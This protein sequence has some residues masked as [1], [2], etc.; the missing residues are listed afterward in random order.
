MPKCNIARPRQPRRSWRMSA[1]CIRR[2]AA[3]GAD[4]LAES[5]VVAQAPR[6]IGCA[7]RLNARAARA[8]KQPMSALAFTIENHKIARAA[9]SARHAELKC[10]T[11]RYRLSRAAPSRATASPCW[12]PA[13]GA[14]FGASAAAG[15]SRKV[16]DKAAKVSR[17]TGKPLATLDVIGAVGFVLRPDPRRRS[18]ASRRRSTSRAG[19]KL[20]GTIQGQIRKSA[21]GRPSISTRPASRSAERKRPTSRSAS[22]CAPTASTSTGPRRTTPTTARS[23]PRSR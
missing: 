4:R 6:R 20:G 8:L 10:P 12:S 22:C 19:W 13:G 3:V 14:K 17:F 16:I 1:T 7:R 9:A 11:H 23:R 5:A 21:E 18:S 2:Q 15:R